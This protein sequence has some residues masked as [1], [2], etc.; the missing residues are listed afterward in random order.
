MADKNPYMMVF[1][2]YFNAKYNLWY[3]DD[4]KSIEESKIDILTNIFD[5]NQTINEPTHNLNNSSSYIDLIFTSQPIPVVESG[6]HSSLHAICQHQIANVKF[7]LNVIYSSSCKSWGVALQYSKFR[8]YS[9]RNVNF[10]WKK[11]FHDVD[12][13]QQLMLFNEAVL[14]IIWNFIPDGTVTFDDRDP[15]Y[16]TSCIKKMINNKSLAI[17]FCE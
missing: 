5:F 12:V 4:N 7:N 14:N 13:K 1:V 11:L 9:T 2:G 6:V 8:V 17:K 3:A 16:I 15:P 10:G